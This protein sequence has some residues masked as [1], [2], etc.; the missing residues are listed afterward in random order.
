M[1]ELSSTFRANV[2]AV[3]VN[4]A[5]QVLIGER[6]GI[7]GAWQ[8]PQGGIRQ[9]EEPFGAILREIAEETGI[10]AA[11]LDLIATHPEWL[12]YELPDAN[13]SEKTGRGQVQRWFLFR[14]VGEVPDVLPD[15]EFSD[16]RWVSVDETAALVVDFKRP[17]YEKLATWVRMELGPP[18]DRL[19]DG[20]REYVLAELSHVSGAI[21]SNEEMGERR[22][23]NFVTLIALLATAVGLTVET[24]SDARDDDK[25]WLALGALVAATTIG[26][27]T[28]RR[29]L[30]RNVATT[31][32]QRD[33]AQLRE[34]LTRG[35][36]VANAVMLFK[37]QKERE[38]KW[39]NGGL[40]ETVAVL[41]ALLIAGAVVAV[42]ALVGAPGLVYVAVA[43]AV[44]LGAL[45]AYAH[46]WAAK[47]FYQS[48]L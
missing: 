38:F 35:D 12:A 17:T 28:F 6:I 23:I 27:L 4:G 31:R 40:A 8:F 43:V 24:L 44:V 42:V 25:L 21:L 33:A 16:T 29:I 34:A 5:G 41:N 9:G 15:T 10:S 20:G 30:K 47:R 18:P 14:L 11:S 48:R 37:E 22:V 3:I 32:M 45:A 2:G 39:R 13:R 1:E 46:Q 36:T 26:L 19:S 7:A